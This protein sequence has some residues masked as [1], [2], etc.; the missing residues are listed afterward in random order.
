MPRK[1]SPPMSSGRSIFSAYGSPCGPSAQ[2]TKAREPPGRASPT[3]ICHSASSS[4][5]MASRFASHA[6]PTAPRDLARRTTSGGSARRRLP[7]SARSVAR[8]IR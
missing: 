4:A 8:K 6:S 5:I 2:A 1:N 7:G 3:E